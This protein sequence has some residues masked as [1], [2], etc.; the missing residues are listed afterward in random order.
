[1]L[2][3][4][5][6]ELPWNSAMAFIIFVTWYYPI[7]M[8]RNAIPAGQVHERGALMFLLIWEF[9]LFTSTFTHMAIAA[10]ELADAAA[11]LANLAFSLCLIFCGVLA[12]PAQ[13]PG[14]WIFMYRV[15]PFTYLVSSMLAVGLA[16]TNVTCASDEFLKF[17]APA[18]QTCATYMA[19]YIAASGGYLQNPNATSCEFCRI[20]ETNVF[21]ASVNSFYGQRWR[22]FG[23]LWAYVIFNVCGAVFLYW[24]A[25][26]PKKQKEKVE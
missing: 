10:I 7:G 8:Y 6:V 4:I 3:N 5:I 20:S 16:N 1:M 21:L 22:N 17:S 9:L 12:G 14:F 23:F 13:L 15:S 26:V 18:G 19:D 11:N 24:L 2:S 25:R